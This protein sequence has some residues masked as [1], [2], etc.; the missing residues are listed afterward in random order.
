MAVCHKLSISEH[1]EGLMAEIKTQYYAPVEARPATLLIIDKQN[2]P[3][4][5]SLQGD[6]TLGR[7]YPESTCDIRVDS[8]ITGRRQGEFIYDDSDDSYYYIDNNSTNGTFING[9]KLEPFNERGTKAF[10]LSDGDIIR[11]DRS[12]LNVPHPESVLIIFSRSFEMNENWELRN[13]A[14]LNRITIGRDAQNT[15]ALNNLMVSREH[16]VIERTEEGLVLSDL[17]SQNG[18]W[19]NMRAVEES[20]LIYNH[21]VLRITNNVLIILGDTILYNNPKSADEKTGSLSVE[22]RRKTVNFGRKTIIK[23]ISFDANSKDFVLILGGSGAGKTTL[24]NAILGDGKADGRVILEGQDLYSNFKSLKSQIGLVPQ[25][26]N[27]R[28]N[29]KVQQTLMDV[30][31]IK[32]DKRFYSK[33]DKLRRIDEILDRLGITNLR[34]HLIRQLSGGQKK[35]VSVAVQLLGFQKVFICDEPDSGLD[36]ASRMQQMEILKEISNNGKIVMIISHEPDD[37]MNKQTGEYYFTKVLVIAKS[38]KEGCGKL[39]F[40]GTPDEAMA[41]F[42]VDC[43]Q[44][45]MVEINPPHEGGKGMADHYIDKFTNNH[46]RA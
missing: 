16:A 36:A 4:M 11:I 9:E 17:D 19:L 42:G 22:I 10:K 33:E 39:A 12:K 26:I 6:T 41:H 31:D 27:L 46:R 7:H 45:I 14:N 8:A 30:A 43:L 1:P 35:K 34:D 15:I 13:I 32:L 2:K 21:D 3:F 5:W 25:F 23:D 24:I 37:A 44:D 40:F 18:M 20:V 28:L 38:A 29:D